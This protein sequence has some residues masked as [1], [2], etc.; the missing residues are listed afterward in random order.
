MV[1]PCLLKKHI[2]LVD[3]QELENGTPIIGKKIEK[4]HIRLGFG[5]FK[6]SALESLVGIKKN[7][8]RQVSITI[9]NKT[10]HYEILVHKV[11]EQ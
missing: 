11:E 4:Q 5:P 3:L 6:D 10:L 9:E 7:E 2:L 1:N 8:K